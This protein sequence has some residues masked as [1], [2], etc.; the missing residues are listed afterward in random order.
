MDQ[1]RL[2]TTTFLIYTPSQ[3]EP[4]VLLL[5]RNKKDNDFHSGKYVG[6]GG[7]LDGHETP[8]QCAIREIREETGYSIPSDQLDFRG[9]VYFD[10]LKT[11]TEN[12]D[13][14]AFH[15]IVFLYS[16]NV[17]EK[18]VI[19]S[20][21]GQLEW[22]PISQVPNLHMWEADKTYSDIIINSSQIIEYLFV[23]DEDRVVKSELNVIRKQ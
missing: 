13:I 8:Y 7:K 4:E 5:F 3:G 18:Q 1:P 10:Q 11:Q 17:D 9:Y 2:G 15:W 16:A 19:E 6:I 14:A 12:V 23:Y 21:E 22:V 20:L